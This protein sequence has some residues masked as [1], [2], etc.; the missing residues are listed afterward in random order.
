MIQCTKIGGRGFAHLALIGSFMQP[1]NT[2]ESFIQEMAQLAS[3]APAEPALLEAAEPLL[4]ELIKSDA[5]LPDTFR[6]ASEKTYQQLLPSSVD[7]FSKE[8]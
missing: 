7:A 4:A 6:V 3:R 2:F 1:H 5:W 8:P